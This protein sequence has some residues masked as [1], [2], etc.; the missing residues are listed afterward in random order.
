MPRM[1]SLSAPL[2]LLLLLLVACQQLPSDAAWNRFRGPNG[3][4]IAAGTGYPAQ[5]GP[6]TNVLWKREF[7]PGFSSPALSAERLFLT[8]LDEERLFTYAID[9]VSGETVWKREAPRP[10]RIEFQVLN[11]PA[12][13]SAAVDHD[14][15][16]V[17]FDE[18]GLLAYDHDG[19][20]RWRMP[21]GPFDNIYAMGASPILVDDVVVLACDQSTDS[22]VI[23][24]SKYDGETVWR[25]PRPS[26]TSGHCTPVVYRT[27]QGKDQV[28][29]PGSYL[30]DAYDPLTGERL[31]WVRG[32]PSEMKSVPVL[33][34]DTLWTHGFASPV[35]NK[36]QQ[37]FLPPFDEALAQMDADGDQLIVAGE[38]P[39]PQVARLF[40]F[41]D[42]NADGSL[43]AS[44][45]AGT[46]AAL[47]AVNSAMAIRMGGVGDVTDTH[48]LWTSYRDISQLPSPL[49]YRGKY[50]MLAD[51]G[52]LLTLLDPD[53][54]ERIEKG[55]LAHAID[56]YYTSPVAADGKVYLVGESGILT[57]LDADG[58]FEPLCTVDFEEPCYATPALEDGQVWLRTEGHLFCFGALDQ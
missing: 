19:N 34:G 39:D 4:G 22:F 38:I 13:A 26:A 11:H 30:L 46:R 20:E 24:V 16:V 27:P 7:P 15:V 41:F 35:N 57:V 28:I 55:R 43:D 23:G 3:T 52:G 5:L 54:G 49:V 31:W 53:T 36:G 8:A 50:Y 47:E 2:F 12:S 44:E 58:R 33:A 21:L 56:A 1:T 32:L 40:P 25:E 9:R 42:L 6:E 51:Q 29:L 18:Y 45:W 48:V 10:R 14:T 17:F 37:V